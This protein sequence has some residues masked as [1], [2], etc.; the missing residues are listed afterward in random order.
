MESVRTQSGGCGPTTTL[1]RFLCQNRLGSLILVPQKT[2]AFQIY[3][4]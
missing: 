2:T 4:S 3:V 1:A